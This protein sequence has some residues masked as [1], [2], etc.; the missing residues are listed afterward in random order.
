MTIVYSAV[1]AIGASDPCGA[2]HVK[3]FVR[4]FPVMSIVTSAP[5]VARPIEPANL[6]PIDYR[7][8]NG[9]RPTDLPR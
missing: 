7:C 2:A 5:P 8:L 1:S 9:D 6:R 3:N 4:F